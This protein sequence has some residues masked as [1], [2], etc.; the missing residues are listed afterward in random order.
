[1]S[2]L[3]VVKTYTEEAPPMRFF[4]LRYTHE[5]VIEGSF[6]Q[7][8]QEWFA[9][10]RFEKMETLLGGP[11][12]FHS[13]PDD[14]A[15]SYLG[16]M[17][18]PAEDDSSADQHLD[19]FEY[20]IG[21]LAPAGTELPEA[22]KIEGVDTIDLPESKVAVGWLKGSREAIF[23]QEMSVWDALHEAGIV[24]AEW[25]ADRPLVFF[26]RYHDQRFMT[27]DE[28]G[29]IILDIGFYID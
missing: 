1:M 25:P 19:T 5:D 9:S 26:E 7:Q 21:R 23:G 24:E 8:W 17:R 13:L 16:L 12:T 27:E 6:S 22:M 14:M 4:G 11:E 18:L 29:R 10:E 2:N 15:D 3:Q 20:W 28:E